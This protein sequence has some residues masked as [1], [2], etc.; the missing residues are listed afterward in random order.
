MVNERSRYVNKLII[1]DGILRRSWNGYLWQL[2]LLVGASTFPSLYFTFPWPDERKGTP[3]DPSTVVSMSTFTRGFF[4]PR[5]A[6]FCFLISAISI[7]RCSV[8][9]KLASNWIYSSLFV[10][11]L[12]LTIYY[13]RSFLE[14]KI[15][16]QSLHQCDLMYSDSV[17]TC[18]IFHGQIHYRKVH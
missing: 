10:L 5:E 12:P 9:T 4:F 7:L 11:F 14:V 15:S 2:K 17:N 18:C 13:R 6:F 1:L 3:H 16:L 8:R